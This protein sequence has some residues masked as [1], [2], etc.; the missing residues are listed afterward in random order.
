MNR[1]QRDFVDLIESGV[2][3]PSK[4][5]DEII[6]WISF[7]DLCQLVD[8]AGY[9]WFDEGDQKVAL[10]DGCVCFNCKDLIEY[11]NIDEEAIN[12]GK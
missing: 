11:M 4:Y 1:E 7:S 10:M 12:Y 8:L 5:A 6:V 3:L 9:D 2:Q